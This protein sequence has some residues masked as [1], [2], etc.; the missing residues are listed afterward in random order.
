MANQRVARR[1]EQAL[2]VSPRKFRPRP[3]QVGRRWHRSS[4]VAV[5]YPGCCQVCHLAA[6]H[7]S[8][9]P[10][11]SIPSS[12]PGVTNRMLLTV[13]RVLRPGGWCQFIEYYT[14]SQS[15][16]GMIH[17][18]SALRRWSTAYMRA[19]EDSKDPRAPMQLQTWCAAAGLQCVESRM[20]PVPFCGW[21]SSKSCRHLSPR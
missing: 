7:V 19:M 17:E 3:V 14:M 6:C 16:N 13:H 4:T 11:I 1:L 9:L 21:P 18:A 5:V 15:D 2:H 12:W 10:S 20:I 8:R